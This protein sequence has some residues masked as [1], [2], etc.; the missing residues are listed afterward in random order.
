M[1]EED[2]RSLGQAMV[3]SFAEL[4]TKEKVISF[5]NTQESSTIATIMKY[6][7]VGDVLDQ[8]KNTIRQ[9]IKKETEVKISSKK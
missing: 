8:S 5:K 4:L 2:Y 1:L 9:S 6:S 3:G 7:E